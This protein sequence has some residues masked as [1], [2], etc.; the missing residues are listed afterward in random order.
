[1]AANADIRDILSDGMVS[2]TCDWQIEDFAI[3]GKGIELSGH[4]PWLPQGMG[5]TCVTALE[6][7]CHSRT[8]ILHE[9]ELE[10]VN[11]LEPQRDQV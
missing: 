6:R 9:F 3:H 5:L 1:M 10:I 8:T 11:I 4:D 2:A 7:A